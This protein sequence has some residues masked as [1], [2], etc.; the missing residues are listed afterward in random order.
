[1]HA[2]LGGGSRKKQELHDLEPP[3]KRLGEKGVSGIARCYVTFLLPRRGFKPLIPLPLQIFQKGAMRFER[4]MGFR[5][6]TGTGD[7]EETIVIDV[8]GNNFI[9]AVVF[10]ER[11]GIDET[12]AERVIKMSKDLVMPMM[13]SSEEVR[14]WYAL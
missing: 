10:N 7:S 8:V 14:L 1:M 12:L 3:L 11:I 13:G 5:L 9:L 4:L 2:L 6:A